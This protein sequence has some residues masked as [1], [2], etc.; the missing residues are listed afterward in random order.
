MNVSR[1][2]LRR[3]FI[4]FLCL[5][6]AVLGASV[7]GERSA[8]AQNVSVISFGAPSP[9]VTGAPFTVTLGL[10][11]SGV[12]TSVCVQPLTGA[13][14]GTV[15]IAAPRN[16]CAGTLVDGQTATLTWTVTFT[17]ASG[18]TSGNLN[19]S[20]FVVWDQGSFSTSAPPISI[21][22]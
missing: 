15:V 7:G 19:F 9:Q 12:S 11:S 17:L 2:V 18:Q 13:S 14:G 1:A 16:K 4:R 20:A 10:Q 3:R 8:F 22:P 6:G 21:I 5:A